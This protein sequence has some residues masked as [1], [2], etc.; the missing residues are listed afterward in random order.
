[1]APPAWQHGT[2]HSLP[3]VLGNDDAE[4][5]R[6]I[7]ALRHVR[8]TASAAV[9]G[10]DAAWLGARELWWPTQTAFERGVATD[11]EAFRELISSGGES[12]TLLAQAERF[13]R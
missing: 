10:D 2:A 6:R 9:H 1:M 12:V 4:L 8:N 13:L 5:G 7:G 3:A 11:P